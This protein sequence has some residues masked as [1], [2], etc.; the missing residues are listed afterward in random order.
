MNEI[1]ASTAASSPPRWVKTLPP[2]AGVTLSYGSLFNAGG[3]YIYY[4]QF[5]ATVLPGCS[6]F[7]LHDLRCWRAASR[8]C[9]AK[10]FS[11]ALLRQA[12]T[13]HAVFHH[14][15]MVEIA[16]VGIFDAASA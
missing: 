5:A 15:L 9:Q 11:L 16:L 14:L 3:S 8:C 6:R 13:V 10:P 4:Q 12:G 2:L 1:S 7:D